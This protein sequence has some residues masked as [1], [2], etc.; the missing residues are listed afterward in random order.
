MEITVNN[1]NY[2]E[3][4]ALFD[5]L[6]K[7]VFGFS[8]KPWFEQE[9]WD[10]RYESYSI[11][12]DNKMLSNLCIYKTEMSSQGQRFQAIQLGAVCTRKSEQSKGLSRLLMEHVL[13]IY[14]NTP[15][16]L[17]A[18]ES[19]ID[20]YP[21]FGFRQVQT[22]RPVIKATKNNKR[23]TAV[24]LEADDLAVKNAIYSRT[25]HSKILD[26]LDTDPIQV[27]HMLMSYP[28]DIY[29]LP[30]HDAIIVAQKKDKNLF[31]ADVITNKPI[32]FEKIKQ[33]LPFKDI[34]TIEF[35][36]CPDRL[37]ITPTWE[38]IDMK[39]EMLFIKGDWNLPKT[40]RIP[41]TSI[42]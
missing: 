41:A 9:L 8:F 10:N 1:H 29:Y 2:K 28:D 32:K 18:N 17:F 31:I 26:C 4:E 11:I 3:Y 16:F 5:D 23:T 7:E 19:V 39:E 22:H 38:P 21:R 33:E 35:G 12:Q 37:E 15:A 6:I 14:K 36:F 40:F 24:K 27:F 34:E 30:T 13:N 42:T 20:F 25:G